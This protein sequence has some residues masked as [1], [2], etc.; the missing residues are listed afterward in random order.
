M[1]ESIAPAFVKIEYASAYGPHVQII[2]TRAYTPPDATYEAGHFLDWANED[3]VEADAMI[4]SLLLAEAGW[5]PTTTSFQRF[6]IF[7]QASPSAPPLPQYTQTDVVAG[8]DATPGWTQAVQTTITL[9][10]EGFKLAKVVLLDTVTEDLFGRYST[11]G[12][13]ARID[14][15]VAELVLPTWAW[16][17]RDGTRPNI[18]ISTCFTLNEKLRRAY[19]MA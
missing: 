12:G 11:P 10:T 14:N 9:R 16:S 19:H 3:P 7:T 5:L 13:I 1:P 18:M 4:H 17:G 2:P 8:T 15:I 6:T